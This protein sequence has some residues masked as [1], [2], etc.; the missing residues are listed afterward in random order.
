MRVHVLFLPLLLCVGAAHGGQEA[1][2]DK[3][4]TLRLL[5]SWN[6]G[7]DASELAPQADLLRRAVKR[8]QETAPPD[9]ANNA[10]ELAELA[11]ALLP[12]PEAAAAHATLLA[13]VRARQSQLQADVERLKAETPTQDAAQ[14]KE[15]GQRLLRAEL[16]AA[17]LRRTVA[18]LESAAGCGQLDGQPAPPLQI[19]WVRR[20]DGSTPWR[21]LEDLRGKVVVVD[22]W[23]TW[24]GPCVAS[25]PKMAELRTRWP[26]SQVEIVGVTSLQGK[27][28]HR[29]R[30]PVACKDQPDLEREETLAFM[31]DMGMTWTV[32]FTKESVFNRAWGVAGIPS[33]AVLDRQGRVVRAGLSASDQTALCAIVDRV[34]ARDASPKD[35]ASPP[36]PP[37][38]TGPA[39]R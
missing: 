26:Q 20:A 21:S 6:A 19:E 32:A 18:R 7:A 9:L 34:L 35:P 36:R 30:P 25:F 1:V 39:P 28:S 38:D 2:D 23:A 22:F 31:K 4:D 5:Q 16:A 3:S 24:C 13:G 27:V 37:S 11:R 8:F 33:V 12:A 17:T 15:R 29:T 10:D 14:T